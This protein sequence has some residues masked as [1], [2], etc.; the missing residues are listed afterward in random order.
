VNS[1]SSAQ[2]ESHGNSVGEPS[3][4]PGVA[5]L[6]LLASIVVS[7]LAASSAP[8]PL[9]ATYARLWHFSSITTTV[10][11]GVYA[12]AV[13]LALLVVG[14]VSDHVGRR[15]VL[16]VALAVQ[17]VALV[18]LTTAAGVDTL[19]IGRVLQGIASGGSI[20]ALGAAMLDVD[21]VRGTRANAAAPGL[22]TGM[23]AIVS[24]LLVQYVPAPTHLVYLTLIAIF[25]LQGLA[26]VRMPET[27]TTKPGVRAALIPELAVPAHLRG[28]ALAATPIL[29]AVWSLAGF[30]G[31]L[32][33]AL[34]GRLSGSTS[35]VIGGLGFFLLATV[36]ALTTV[37][38]DRVRPTTVM[39]IGIAVMVVAAVC[40]TISIDQSSTVGLFAST[41]V[42]GVGFGAGFQGGIRTVIPLAAAHERSGVL[43]ALYVVCYLGLGVPSVIAGVL[44]VHGGGLLSTARDY[45]I[46]IVLL[47]LVGLLMTRS[48]SGGERTSQHNTSGGDK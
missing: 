42:A 20:G 6:V 26:V 8:T 29:F 33:P 35:A 10:I 2:T 45:L 7:S 25:V 16:L 3:R 11:F 31:S 12:I 38:L 28:P 47:A 4:R 48:R 18:L 17:A 39:L 23:G 21:P 27:V 24:G 36:G 1:A 34:A 15:P 41:V 37:A 13:L 22:G 14:R 9:Y 32:G 46:F 5:S 19:V 30:Y 44:V 40:T 43:S